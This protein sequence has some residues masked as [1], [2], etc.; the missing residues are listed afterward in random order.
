MEARHLS[1]LLD[2]AV[3]G[4]P[5]HPAVEDEAGRLL[6]YAAL[7]CGA[8]RLAARLARWGI[9]RGDRVGIWLPKCSE[10][11]V[12]IHGILRSGAAYVPVDPTSPAFRATNI[13]AAS[14]VKAAVVSAELGASLRASWA[15]PAPLP[16]LIV[17]DGFPPHTPEPRP[18]S[19]PG[20]TTEEQTAISAGDALWKD[21]ITDEAPSPLLPARCCDD[22]AYILFTSGS[23]GQP[24]GVMLSH[25]S[26]CAFLDWCHEA[27]APWSGDDR[28]AS[29]APF[30]FDL[31]IFDIFAACR[32]AA[33]LVL[34]GEQL[35]KDPVQ[36]GEFMARQAITVW[37]SAPSI[38]VLLTEYG[39]LDRPG[40]PAPRLVL[41]AGEVFPVAALRKLRSLWPRSAMWNL[42][43]PTETNVCTAF[44]IPRTV[45]AD[46]SLAYPIGPVCPPLRA[47]VVDERCDSLP[48]GALGE[49]VIAGP[50]VMRG[51]FGQ[52]EVTADSFLI[53]ADGTRWYR[54]G[55]LV[56]DDGTGCFQF[57]GRRDR[58]V[59]KRGYRI[60]LGEIESALHFHNGVDR[61]GV[62]ARV[63]EMGVSIA[64]FVTL[65]PN[66]KKSIVALKRHCTEY[67][68]GY[69]IPDTIT[70][71]DNLPAT[72]TDKV[73]YQRLKLMATQLTRCS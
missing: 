27:L 72:S 73:D 16:R 48:A 5:D 38:L 37:Y 63:D 11:V 39:N 1:V 26:A 6:S 71:L 3:K 33:T 61:A 57:H 49:L 36:L 22:L 44:P 20:I 24:K 17:L 59:K 15:G 18:A 53:D 14:G 13:L 41:F 35:S 58:M 30:H 69:M 25:R 2:E 60:E 7:W 23:T 55:D 31:S 43:G 40:L 64:A 67:L 51:Y 65:K 8:D 28:F 66:Q 34:I 50:A 47:R 68:P 56:R 10:S 4:R 21:V 70:F 54:T 12:A 32:N 45:P 9:G 52:P 46:R 19:D 62:V 29:H 42:Y